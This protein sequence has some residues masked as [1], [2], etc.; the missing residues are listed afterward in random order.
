MARVLSLDLSTSTGYALLDGEKIEQCGVLANGKTAAEYAA[1]PWGVV[2]AAVSIA[3]KV[4]A[5]VQNTGHIDSI[6]I[7]E[8]NLGRNR[9]SQKQLEFIHFAVLEV[10]RDTAIPVHYL[11]TGVWRKHLGIF[12]SKD[13]KRQNS[14]LQRAKRAAANAGQSLDKKEL[15][16]RGKVNKKH[17]AI[18]Y[19]NERFNLALKAKDDDV[20]DA[21]CLALAYVG[22]APVCDGIDGK[23]SKKSNT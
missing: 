7:E 13:D 6:V 21:I 22:G 17:I 20:A 15:G 11:S 23:K 1:Y 3:A 12:L 16:I 2:Q 14:R 19:V 18:R 4:H 9:Y 10:L 8:T 5:L